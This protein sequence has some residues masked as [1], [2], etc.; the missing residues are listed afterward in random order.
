MIDDKLDSKYKLN[1]SVVND[2]TKF[3]DYNNNF[4]V[5][6]SYDDAQN[7]RTHRNKTNIVSFSS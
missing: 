3:I 2:N 4:I 7:Q 5:I 1:E 6:N